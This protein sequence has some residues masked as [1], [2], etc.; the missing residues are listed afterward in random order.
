MPKKS[1]DEKYVNCHVRNFTALGG[2]SHHSK[3]EA[4]EATAPDDIS[5]DE[6]SIASDPLAHEDRSFAILANFEITQF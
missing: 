2:S 4:A 5:L 3:G 1:L 6:G